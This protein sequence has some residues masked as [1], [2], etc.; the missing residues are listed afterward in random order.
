MKSTVG[1]PRKISDTQVAVILAWYASP[2]SIPALARSMG[3]SPSAVDNCIRCKGR[4]KQPSPEQRGE[5][6]R[7]RRARLKK[8]HT[9]GWL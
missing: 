8:L 9:A 1:R 6:V 5:S 7:S 4:Y 3:L 2:R